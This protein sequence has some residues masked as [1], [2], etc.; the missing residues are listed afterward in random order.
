VAAWRSIRA[1]RLLS[2][3][4]PLVRVPIA[5]DGPPDGWRERDQD[6]LGAFAAHAQDPVIVFLA[7]VGDVGPG[8]FED[9]Q[10]Q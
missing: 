2:R 7:E 6:D 1:P 10:A 9:P 3:I 4:G 8:G 5:V